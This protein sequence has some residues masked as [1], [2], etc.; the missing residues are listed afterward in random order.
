[1]SK[2]KTSFV[3]KADEGGYRWLPGVASREPDVCLA[4]TIKYDRATGIYER[5]PELTE[6]QILKQAQYMFDATPPPSIVAAKWTEQRLYQQFQAE[7]KTGIFLPS[8]IP[9]AL[10]LANAVLSTSSA[11]FSV[12]D[13]AKD[14]V[15]DLG[16]EAGLK[17]VMDI[18]VQEKNLL[19][20][21]EKLREQRKKEKDPDKAFMVEFGSSFIL[22]SVALASG[23][24]PFATIPGMLFTVVVWLN[25][26]E[27]ARK[28]DA[29]KQLA[30]SIMEKYD[31]IRRRTQDALD[32]RHLRE[33][34]GIVATSHKQDLQDAE[35]YGHYHLN[36]EVIAVRKLDIEVMRSVAVRF[37]YEA[38]KGVFRK[39]ILDREL[40]L[41]AFS[42]LKINPKPYKV[43]QELE[44]ALSLKKAAILEFW[45]NA[46][47][48][49]SAFPDLEDDTEEMQSQEQ[50]NPIAGSGPKQTLT[51]TNNQTRCA[52]IPQ[53]Q[54]PQQPQ[55]SQGPI[56]QQR[57]KDIGVMV[58]AQR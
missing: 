54:Q 29:N 45:G 51:E 48:D 6:E 53:Q 18:V 11:A 21:Q 34:R 42:Y 52:S 50:R 41:H 20:E 37:E 17:T 40:A 27:K 36:N 5:T 13:V 22:F 58:P 7:D 23:S 43:L 49:E 38:S 12:L 1:M 16:K 33:L 14:Y 25:E 19:P 35:L 3:P 56:N 47:A 4:E 9:K 39:I 24:C 55:K 15:K 2:T 46:L 30:K 31:S 10:S 26:R 44:E 8:F 57:G 28:A 32:R